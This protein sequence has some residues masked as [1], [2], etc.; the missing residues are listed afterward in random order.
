MSGGHLDQLVFPVAGVEFNSASGQTENQETFNRIEE[1]KIKKTRTVS[2]SVPKQS[3]P[4]QVSSTSRS[5]RGKKFQNL[6]EKSNLLDTTGYVRNIMRKFKDVVATIDVSSNEVH[7]YGFGFTP[8]SGDITFI[9]CTADFAGA[10]EMTEFR[11]KVN[12]KMGDDKV[13]IVF[14]DISLIE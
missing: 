14:N 1:P 3:V 13:H 12:E 10:V 8:G 4:N 7:P 5:T 6:D 9:F 2:Y 11:A